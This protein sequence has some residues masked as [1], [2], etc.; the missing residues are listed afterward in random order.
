VVIAINIRSLP[1]N[2]ETAELL[3][4]SFIKLAETNPAHTFIFISNQ[5]L[6]GNIPAFKN[7][8][9]VVLP[10]QSQNPLLWLSMQI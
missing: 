4:A 7:I 3:T 8:E 5:P 6:P 1:G 2:S 9:T 10:Q